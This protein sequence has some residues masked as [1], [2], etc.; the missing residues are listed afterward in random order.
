MARVWIARVTDAD[1]AH[2]TAPA[3]LGPGERERWDTLAP[4]RQRAFVASRRLVRAALAQATGVV[5]EQWQVSAEAGVAPSAR[6]VD[7][8]AGRAPPV[9]IAHRLGWVAVA[10]GGT[11]D[12]AIG[13]DIECERPKNGDPARRAALM[14]AGDE[15]ARWTAL[16]EREREPALL[17]A[18][19]AREAWF[20]A[21]GA[22]APW[23]FRRMAC[24]PAEAALANVRVWEAGALRVALCAPEPGAASCDGWPDA[25]EVRSSLW[26]VDLR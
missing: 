18:W 2:A 1:A 11:E 12:A 4:A 3:W 13:V 24:E 19:V 6:R 17:R 15:L 26:R 8:A 16:P 25:A 5:A 21:T 23:D 7:G 22:G 10:V 9:S 20:K 14:M